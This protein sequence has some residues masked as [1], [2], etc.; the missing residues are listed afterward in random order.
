VDTTPQPAVPDR[1]RWW[2]ASALAACLLAAGGAATDEPAP[3]ASPSPAVTLPARPVSNSVEPVIDKLEEEE[4]ERC[5]KAQEKGIPCFPVDTEGRAPDASVR[6]LFEEYRPGRLPRRPQP[7]DWMENRPLPAPFIPMVS[8]D[9]GCAAKSIVRSLK[10]KSNTYYLYRMRD[11]HGLRAAL[12][13]RKVEAATFQG[14]LEFLGRFD[15]ECDA[16]AAYRKE[17]RRLRGK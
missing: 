6:E 17:D 15:G 13:D 7:S 2:T 1:R 16:L 8:F 4:K 12:S 10:G 9:P 14:E 11:R 5:R 3:A